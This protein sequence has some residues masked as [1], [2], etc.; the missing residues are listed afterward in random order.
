MTTAQKVA[1]A[2]LLLAG[3]IGAAWVAQ[4]RI[5]V[6]RSNRTVAL[7]LDDLE[8]R[9]LAA[10]MGRS[11]VALMQQF[12]TAGITHLAVSEQTL[13][14]LLQTGQLRVVAQNA[15]TGTA[16]LTGAADLIARVGQALRRVP[17]VRAEFWTAASTDRK[18]AIAPPFP[19]TVTVPTAVLN[20]QSLGVGYDQAVIDAARKAGL[21]IIARPM[22]DYLYTPKAVE[23]SLKTA[24]DAGAAIALFNG[25]SVAGGTKLAKQTA[26]IMNRLGLKFGYVELVPQEG[27]PALAAALKYQIIRTHSISQEEMTKTSATRGLDRFSL[28]VTERNIRLCYIRLMLQPQ[29]DLL[30]ANT[31]YV[32]SISSALGKSGYNTFSEPTP[33]RN[34]WVGKK[35]LALLALGLVGGGLWFLQLVFALPRRYFWGLLIVGVVLATAGS[36]V[37]YAMMRL[38]VSLL[39][40][41]IF[42]S[43]AVLYASSAAARQGRAD[44]GSAK[45]VKAIGLLLVAAGITVLG[46]L[47]IAGSLSSSDYMMQI[48]Q[49]R[50]VKL[51]QLLPL[52][53]VLAV[54]LGTAYSSPNARGWARLREG[55]T[56]V[57]DSFVKYWHA[58]AIFLALGAVG[59]MLMRSGNESAVEVSGLELKMR[60]LLD[61]VLVVRPRTKEIFLGYPALLMGLTLLLSRRRRSAWIWLTIGAIAVVSAT[62]TCCHLHTPLLVSLLRIING[63]WLGIAVGIVWLAAKSVGERILHRIWWTNNA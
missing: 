34:F 55:W 4:G 1:I 27:A 59:F 2:A 63:I 29:A 12:K 16:T 26:E 37:A 35:A 38:F 31:E 17:A 28:A 51:A 56:L 18:S 54:T 22:P 53:I 46:G 41:I 43:L 10:L 7:C 9:Q 39:S 30:K 32:T 13:G 15:L 24:R 11:P 62:N 48:A 33:L 21:S 50:G 52:M 14:Q 19:Y 44:G 45:A 5:A 61:Q 25:V 3:L 58:I 57:A 36:F 40:A 8:V 6:E 47:M 49:F 23:A 42:P 60:A 20:M